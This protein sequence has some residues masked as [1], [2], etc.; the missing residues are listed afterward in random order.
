MIDVPESFARGKIAGAGE[1]AR[2]WIVA[3]PGIVDD[4]LDRWSCTLDG[5]VL[6][7]AV[8]IVV[9]VRPRDLPPAV[10]KVSYPGWADTSE[11]DAYTTW[12]GAG[13]VRILRRDDQHVAMLL[14]RASTRTLATIENADAAVAIQGRLTRRLAVPAPAGLPRISDLV[15]G[16]EHEIRTDAAI[17][18]HPLPRPVVDAAVAT[19]CELGPD[20]PDILVHGDLHDANILAAEREPWLAIDP[21]VCVGD[22]AYNAFTVMYSP[23]FGNLAASAGLRRELLRLLEIY[24]EAAQ[25]DV[26]RARRWIQAGVVREALSGRRDGDPDWLIHAADQWASALM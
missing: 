4:L 2:A 11:A 24:C 22:P 21:K 20:Q 10:I 5:P 14:E 3:V 6:H 23:R 9:P 18:G 12:D 16:W 8:G 17:L 7:G 13:A 19:L 25:I 1:A 15:D 26:A